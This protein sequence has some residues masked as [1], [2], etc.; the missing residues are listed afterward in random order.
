MVLFLSVLFFHQFTKS[1]W[2]VFEDWLLFFSFFVE[3]T[4]FHLINFCLLLSLFCRLNTKQH[5]KYLCKLPTWFLFQHQSNNYGT[6]FYFIYLCVFV[7]FQNSLGLL[8]CH[9][10]KRFTSDLI[11]LRKKKRE[12]SDFFLFGQ[13]IFYNRYKE[14]VRN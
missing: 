6:Y 14:L 1:F 11:I 2:N 5:F 7:Y 12:K 9:R 3:K 10:A 8:C 13:N 4:K